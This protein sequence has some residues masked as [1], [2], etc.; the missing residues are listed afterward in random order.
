M[1]KIIDLLNARPI[2]HCGNLIAHDRAT[3]RGS[4]RMRGAI[5]VEIC[6]T[7]RYRRGP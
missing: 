2:K 7:C 3:G 6:M 1:D 5:S 4:C